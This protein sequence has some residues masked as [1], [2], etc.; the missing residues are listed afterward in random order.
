MRKLTKNKK[1]F[2]F[3]K[4]NKHLIWLIFNKKQSY[5]EDK[6]CENGVTKLN[7]KNR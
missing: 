4:I 3:I 2:G 6:N 7:D 5:F 1:Q